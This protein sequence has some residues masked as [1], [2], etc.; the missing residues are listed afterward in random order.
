[1]KFNL[2]INYALFFCLTMLIA[3][4][5]VARPHNLSTKNQFEI[6]WTTPQKQT[7]VN[8]LYYMNTLS[9]KVAG[10]MRWATNDITFKLYDGCG[11]LLRQVTQ[12]IHKADGLSEPGSVKK[13]TFPVAVQMIP[14][15]H[16]VFE[17]SERQFQT[18][19]IMNENAFGWGRHYQG[20]VANGEEVMHLGFPYRKQDIVFD[21][22]GSQSSVNTLFA[23]NVM[24]P[25]KC[26]VIQES[27]RYFPRFD[28]NVVVNQKKS[29]MV[30]NNKVGEESGSFWEHVNPNSPNLDLTTDIRQRVKDLFLEPDSTTTLMSLSPYKELFTPGKFNLN[31][32][33]AI[34]DPAKDKGLHG[35]NYCANTD[36]L[37][38]LDTAKRGSIRGLAGMATFKMDLITPSTD[39]EQWTGDGLAAGP[40]PAAEHKFTL[41]HEMGHAIAGLA[42]EYGPIFGQFVS[43]VQHANIQPNQDHSGCPSWCDSHR[44]VDWLKQHQTARSLASGFEIH[45]CWEKQTKSSCESMTPVPGSVQSPCMWLDQSA[46]NHSPYWNGNRCIPIDTGSIDIGIGCNGDTQCIAFTPWGHWQVSTNIARAGDKVMQSNQSG[47]HTTQVE[48]HIRDTF[49]C[50][51]QT[52]CNQVNHAKCADFMQ[53]WG[54]NNNDKM[55]LFSQGLACDG[56]WHNR[57]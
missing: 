49:E 30:N 56:N 3:S 46:V 32:Y 50:L 38:S 51:F 4:S 48:D 19:L 44:D 20:A 17:V 14:N 2:F 57:R 8:D 43:S 27:N 26:K 36:L 11:N 21:T 47:K 7:F 45:K 33:L 52:R 24:C 40:W 41:V 42:D 53:Q 16:Y 9:I 5:V 55:T 31:L 15:K 34:E 54:N 22:T 6:G 25:A 13:I 23:S 18:K 37:V 10:P 29:I 35:L 28:F 1:M 12:T 39:S